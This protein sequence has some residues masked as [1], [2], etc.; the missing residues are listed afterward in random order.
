MPS[1][2]PSASIVILTFNS[3]DY[4]RPCLDSLDRDGSPEKEIL[5]IDNASKDNTVNIMHSE[6]SDISLIENK[7]NLGVAGGWNQGWLET[8]GDLVVF[9]NPDLELEPGWLRAL[10]QAMTENPEADVAGIKLFEMDRKT[11]QHTGAHLYP[12]A[13]NRHRGAGEFD[14]GQ[15]DALQPIECVTGAVLCVRRSAL[16]EL[17]GF[18]EDFYPAYYEE[19]DFCLRVWRRGRQVIYVPNAVAYHHQAVTI[20]PDTHEFSRLYFRMRNVFVI[21]NYSWKQIL[22]KA[23]PWEVRVFFKHWNS[24]E[25]SAA[26]G[27]YFWI[28]PYAIQRL[29]RKLRGKP[30]RPFDARLKDRPAPKVVPSEKIKA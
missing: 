28:M 27:S 7:E 22:F 21:K 29:M 9:L 18:D 30:G 24:R 3:Q 2:L 4:I 15:Y 1:D 19:V 6:F 26:I 14:N 10:Q 5:I 20:K 11:L 12:N 17:G 13:Q 16:E 23:L 8:K 25:R